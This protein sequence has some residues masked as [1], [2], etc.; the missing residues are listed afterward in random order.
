M[1][2][3][4][5]LTRYRSV[6]QVVGQSEDFRTAT[7]TGGLLHTHSSLLDSRL[8][9]N[10]GLSHAFWMHQNRHARERGHPGTCLELQELQIDHYCFA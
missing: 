10:D 9:G 5:D 8:R 4:S 2:L 3:E 6:L 7:P 1:L